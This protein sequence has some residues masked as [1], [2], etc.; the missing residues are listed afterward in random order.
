[1]LSQNLCPFPYDRDVI[2]GWPRKRRHN[3]QSFGTY[4]NG[5]TERYDCHDSIRVS[6]INGAKVNNV[7]SGDPDYHGQDAS[8]AHTGITN[9]EKLKILA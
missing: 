2:Y 7:G 8:E 5:S 1:M 4:S 9:A 6:N 3:N